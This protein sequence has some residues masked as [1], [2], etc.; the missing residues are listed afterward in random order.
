MCDL[1]RSGRASAA[2]CCSPYRLARILHTV[3]RK[4]VVSARTSAGA[5]VAG[6]MPHKL[7]VCQLVSW[8]ARPSGSNCSSS[9]SQ[10]GPSSL[11]HCSHCK[12]LLYHQSCAVIV[13]HL[14]IRHQPLRTDLIWFLTSSSSS[15]GLGCQSCWC[16]LVDTRPG[17]AVLL[18]ANF[19][20]CAQQRLS[21]IA[22]A[23]CAILNWS[24]S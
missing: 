20:A 21:S 3:K 5:H 2:K 11:K 18:D 22:F 9:S 16:P 10:I 12:P 6:P 24:T 19:M 15:K 17:Q 7:L 1:V 14:L 4:A 13:A 23:T 8:S